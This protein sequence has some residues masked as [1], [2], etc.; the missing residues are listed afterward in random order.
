MSLD[1][2]PSPPSSMLTFGPFTLHRERRLLTTA[3]GAPVAIGSRALDILTVLIDADG[4]LL[5]KEQ[6]LA[7]VWA[8]VVV[9]ESTL[10]VH[11]AGLRKALGDGKD[12]ARYVLNE[13]GRGYRFVAE[14]TR[15]GEA[16]PP[17]ASAVPA[18]RPAPERRAQPGGRRVVG[19]DAIVDS[20]AG[21]LPERGFMT[22][23]GPGG[24]GKTTV[25]AAVAERV[26]QDVGLPWLF[27]DL[28]PVA[29]AELVAGAA[30]A[31]LELP[32]TG[33]D[34]AAAVVAR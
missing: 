20:L 5:S 25:A 16:A 24:I 8:G 13:Q 32:R 19:R 3:D 11:I 10:R 34:A 14:V 7:R 4:G 6:L 21:L 30:A 31:R 2:A 1:S 26:A 23:I 12:G 22:I 15:S 17:P 18:P 29:E 9:D 28:A 27:V 33:A